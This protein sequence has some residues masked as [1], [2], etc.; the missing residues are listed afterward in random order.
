MIIYVP[1]GYLNPFES[2]FSLSS[3]C[4]LFSLPKIRQP[5][6][7]GRCYL[8]LQRKKQIVTEETSTQEKKDARCSR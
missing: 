4:I 6:R 2:L 3:L 8:S 7:E 5:V 1:H